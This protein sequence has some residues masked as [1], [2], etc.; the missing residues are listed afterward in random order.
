MKNWRRSF[1]KV[2]KV[3]TKFAHVNLISRNWRALADFYIT[4]FGCREKKPERDLSGQ[5]LNDL[6]AIPDVHIRGMHLYL[7]GCEGDGPTLEIFEYEENTENPG[8]LINLEG[9]GH[10][11][12]S[13]ENVEETMNLLLAHGGSLVGKPVNGYVEGVGDIS[14]VYARDPEGNIV[15]IQK[16]G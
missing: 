16:W 15:E 6:T 10:I 11:A 4:V 8:K 7:P 14:L 2:M 13:V 3:N 5:W 1:K 12:F 9:F